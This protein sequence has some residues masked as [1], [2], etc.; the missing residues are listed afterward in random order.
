MHHSEAREDI[1]RFILAHHNVQADIDTLRHAAYRQIGRLR[2]SK[3]YYGEEVN[4]MYDEA[5]AIL[6]ELA[7]SP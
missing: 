4:A 5:E 3:G 1:R 6:G 7:Q 2:D